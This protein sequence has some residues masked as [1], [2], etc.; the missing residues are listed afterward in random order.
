MAPICDSSQT[1]RLLSHV[2]KRDPQALAELFAR[3]RERLRK[4][5]RL[6]LDGRLRGRISSSAILEEVFHDVER[7]I[8]EYPGNRSQS[9]FLWLREVT[10]ERLQ[11]LHR[12]HL[13]KAA[14]EVGQEI[15]LHSGAM[16][17]VNA[18]SMAAQL[19]GDRASN[20]AALRA[21]LLLQLQTALNGLDS[22][23]RELLALRHFEELSNESAAA[24]LGLEPAA[25]NIHYLQALKRLNE[26][27]RS[28]PGFFATQREQGRA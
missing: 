18:A 20:Q 17:E 12:Q 26:I 22:L 28:I 19:M 4:M 14:V 8:E 27:L 11:Q 21:D 5:V 2:G 3:H 15:H 23:D 7:R 10:G 6:R 24:V 1:N 9:F 13:G 16:P 25:A